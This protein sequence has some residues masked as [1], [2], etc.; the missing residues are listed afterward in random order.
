MLPGEGDPFFYGGVAVEHELPRGIGVPVRQVE[1]GQLFHG[2]YEGLP[3]AG[4]I[5]GVPVS[6]A[7]EPARQR[8]GSRHGDQA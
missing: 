6:L 5:R 1:V 7:L 2:R 8:V 4:D 3:V